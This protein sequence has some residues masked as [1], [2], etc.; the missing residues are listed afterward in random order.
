MPE[1]RYRIVATLKNLTPLRIGDGGWSN[2]RIQ[3]P[4][5]DGETAGESPEVATVFLGKETKPYLPGTSLKGWLRAFAEPRLP[6]ADFLRLFG[7]TEA[8]GLVRFLD[9]TY[10]ADPPSAAGGA[11]GEYWSAERHT[12]VASHVVIDRRTKTAVRNLLFF[13]EF[14]PTGASFHL[15]FDLPGASELEAAQFLWLI[16]QFSPAK[17]GPARLGAG[18]ADDWGRVR[19]A[20]IEVHSIGEKEF[21]AWVRNT[22][23]G[24]PPLLRWPPERV[25]ELLAKATPLTVQTRQLRIPIHLK[26]DGGFLCNDPSRVRRKD[27]PESEKGNFEPL[28]FQDGAQLLPH[29]PYSSLRG[30]LR[31]QAEKI[32]RTRHPNEAVPSPAVPAG[33]EGSTPVIRREEDRAHLDLISLL[34]GAAG[35]RSALLFRDQIVEKAGDLLKHEL[36]GLDRFS[37]AVGNRKFKA[38][39][40]WKPEIAVELAVDLAALEWASEENLERSAEVLTLL[41]QVLRDLAE[42]FVPLGFGAAKGWG[43]C[44]AL[45]DPGVGELLAEMPEPTRQFFARGFTP[46]AAP[47][48]PITE[49]ATPLPAP[50]QAGGGNFFNPYHFHPA[51]P[52]NHQTAPKLADLQPVTSGQ[53][54]LDRYHDG[55]YT[56]YV[57]CLLT[58]ETPLAIGGEQ[59]PSNDGQPTT[60]AL[61]NRDG[62]VA[63]PATSLRGMVSAHFEALT[64]SALRVLDNQFYSVRREMSQ[65]LSAIGVVVKRS[66]DGKEGWFLKPLCLP[67]YGIHLKALAPEWRALFPTPVLKRYDGSTRQEISRDAWIAARPTWKPGDSLVDVGIAAALNWNHTGTDVVPGNAVHLKN[68]FRVASESG[69]VVQQGIRRTLGAV[70][71]RQMPHGKKHELLIPAPNIQQLFAPGETSTAGL[72]PLPSEVVARFERLAKEMTD[73]YRSP[74]DGDNVRPYEPWGTRATRFAAPGKP[75]ELRLQAGDLVYFDIEVTGTNVSVKEIS[76][77]SIWRQEVL[78]RTFDFFAGIDLD[79]LPMS[80]VRR[81]GPGGVPR[82]DGEVPVTPAERLFGFVEMREKPDRTK[83]LAALA[84]RVRFTDGVYQGNL[85]PNPCYPAQKWKIQSTPKPPSAALYFYKAG[86]NDAATQYIKKTEL[87]NDAHHLPK[88]RKFYPHHAV[89]PELFGTGG[90]PWCSHKEDGDDG[91]KQRMNVGPVKEGAQ[92]RFR[93]QFENVSAE[94]LG[95]LIGALRPAPQVRYKL[96]LGRPLGLGTVRLDPSRVAK[97][98]DLASRYDPANV[99]G[100]LQDHLCDLPIVAPANLADP[101]FL[102]LTGKQYAGI[103]YPKVNRAAQWHQV[104]PADGESKLFEWFVANDTGSGSNTNPPRNEPRGAAM[105]SLDGRDTIEALT[106]F[107]YTPPAGGDQ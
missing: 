34:F 63:I 27:D 92:F 86:G 4:P 69:T 41:A 103:E 6:P 96:G 78:K 73:Q 106:A 20:E 14:V 87:G 28:R 5:E 70:P 35:W 8:G 61:Y 67:S 22:N 30:S 80:D 60:V 54:T 59:T 81:T 64:K 51:K 48:T 104:S 97:V 13:E 47:D 12:C 44:H 84:S 83:P 101:A 85:G 7:N 57:D 32:L 16:H 39:Y 91:D 36:V 75:V 99:A 31:S 55:L 77:S 18:P 1:L 15:V 42:G 74:Q 95:L 71:A 2:T 21:R 107:D 45:I 105:T 76:F 38:R 93:I 98:V 90:A 37:G 94:D 19:A 52:G 46:G 17:G 89:P 26:F 65:G 29:L 66:V 25:S 43:R 72:L 49:D 56:G 62:E 68:N 9:A 100:K 88:G 33:Q 50:V 82:G 40:F 3:R 11:M 10:A 24:A 79:L 102:A 53:L 58:T 23:F